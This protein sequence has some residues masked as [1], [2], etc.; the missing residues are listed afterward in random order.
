MNREFVLSLSAIGIALCQQSFAHR[1][2]IVVEEHYHHP[3]V[4]VK[5]KIYEPEVYVA[6]AP[7]VVAPVYIQEAPPAAI[8]EEIGIS[9]GPDYIW[10]DG[11]W[12]WNNGWGWRRGSWV[13]KPHHDAVWVRGSWEK[14]PRGHVWVG[15]HWK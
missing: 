4:V 7:V 15:G 11:Y 14:H 13:V 10:V 2:H 8:Q 5:E 12:A 9:P 3:H 6:E 1:D